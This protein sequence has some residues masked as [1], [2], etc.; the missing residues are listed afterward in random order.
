MS[1]DRNGRRERERDMNERKWVLAAGAVAGAAAVV[2][3]A[4]AVGLGPLNQDEGWYLYAALETA[5]GRLPYRDFFF[6]QGPLLPVVYGWLAPLWSDAGVLGGRIVTATLGLLASVLVALLAARGATPGGRLAAGVTAFALTACGVYHAYF[7][8]IPKTY[9]LAGLLLAGGLLALTRCERDRRAGLMWAAGSGVLLAAAAGTR[10]SLGAALAVTGLWLLA[11]RRRL[12]LAWLAFGI[13]GVV[14]LALVYG[15][16]VL[17]APEGFYFAQTFHTGRAGGGALFVAGSIARLLRGYLPLAGLATVAAVWRLAGCSRQ[18]ACSVR[19]DVVA[20]PSLWLWVAGAIAAVHLTSPYPYDDYQVPVMP[21]AAAAAAV[22]L[23][24]AAG[25]CTAPA[26]ARTAAVWIV[27]LCSGLATA[28]SPLVQ[29]WFM[30]RQDRFWVVQKKTS[31]LAVLRRV[32]ATLKRPGTRETAPLLLTQ[33]VYLA[34]ES[35]RR[36]PA[37]LEMGPF[38]Y[39][40]DL[41][42]DQ[43]RRVLVLNRARLLEVV[44]TTDA[45]D[46]AT[47]GYAFAIGAPAMT[48][49]DAAEQSSLREALARRYSRTGEVR[50]FGQ[51]WTTLELWTRDGK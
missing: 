36:V 23:M 34:V 46:A 24:G 32:G 5:A 18:D 33:D 19:S 31:D 9:A 14:G 12:G 29:E 17:A 28:A 41:D 1:I 22:W 35:G 7:M 37:G 38:S 20:W 2:I 3:A 44:A 27:L 45:S 15:P 25:R 8:A 49:L 39:F 30:I 6:T 47:S 13:G 50:N 43:A 4:A 51:G 10:L 26:A 21:L 11:H 16:F 40:P 48:E 42:A